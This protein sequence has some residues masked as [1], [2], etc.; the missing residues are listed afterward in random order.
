MRDREGGLNIFEKVSF[1][2]LKPFLNFQDGWLSQYSALFTVFRRE[3][4]TLLLLEECLSV[5]G[6]ELRSL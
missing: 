4:L 1:C 5:R 3:K 6:E 2:Y